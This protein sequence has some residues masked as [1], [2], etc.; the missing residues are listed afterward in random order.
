MA[1]PTD[2]FKHMYSGL[3]EGTHDCRVCAR[4]GVIVL[5]TKF[6]VLLKADCN[7]EFSSNMN[8]KGI[9]KCFKIASHVMLL[10]SY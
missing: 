10:F 9:A 7:L 2:R 1:G 4:A 3:H 5:P 8:A 6:Y